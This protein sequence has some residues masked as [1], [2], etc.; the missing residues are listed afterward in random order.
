M[1]YVVLTIVLFLLFYFLHNRKIKE[2]EEGRGLLIQQIAGKEAES[3]QRYK[4]Q[5]ELE[6]Q[7]AQIKKELQD[8]EAD[9]KKITHQKKSSEVR[10]GQ[11]AEQMAPF[12]DGFPYNP[13][14]SSFLGNPIDFIAFDDN[15]VHFVEIK[16]G[17]SRLTS[18]QRKI[19]DQIN[20]GMVTFE[21]YRIKGE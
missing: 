15:G 17:K 19:R 14:Q 2:Y 6:G 4:F 5:I 21:V 16:S 12:L 11:I 18:A 8:K 7:L 10:T 20:S 13:K 3:A 9:L 1:G